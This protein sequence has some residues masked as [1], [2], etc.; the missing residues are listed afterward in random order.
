MK[1]DSE[2]VKPSHVWW[3]ATERDKLLRILGIGQPIEEK[4]LRLLVLLV[5]NS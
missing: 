5:E 3:L 2:K 4:E 1:K